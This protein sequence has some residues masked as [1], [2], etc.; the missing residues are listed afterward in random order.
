MAAIS[1]YVHPEMENYFSQGQFSRVRMSARCVCARVRTLCVCVCVCVRPSA[2]CECVCLCVSL[3]LCLCICVI[4]C[5]CVRE[6]TLSIEGFKR[7]WRDESHT[8]PPLHH[9]PMKYISKRKEVSKTCF[10]N[11]DQP[12][13]ESW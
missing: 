8:Y 7:G 12:T 1:F 4:L 3:C 6:I 11:I 9:T 10:E 5:E 2:R 13:S